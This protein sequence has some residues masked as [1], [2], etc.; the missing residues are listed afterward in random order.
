MSFRQDP[1]RLPA[2]PPSA[3]S[4]TDVDASPAAA[5]DVEKA[6]SDAEHTEDAVFGKL[7]GG[8]ALDYRAVGAKGAFVLLVKVNLG[9]GVL[10]LPH[11]FGVLG[12]VPGILAILV[13]QT[14]FCYC[15]LMIGRFK[16]AHPQ[17]YTV[18][19]AAA[20][21]GGRWAKEFW[22][23]ALNLQ[24]IFFVAAACVGV[25][26]ALNAVSAHGACTAI[27]IAVAGVLAFMFGA[28]PTLGAI[29]WI[30]WA[31]LASIL[32]AVFTV[33]VA[34]GVQSRPSLA[35]ATGP[36][37][38]NVKMF[39]DA[40]FAQAMAAINQ[41]LFAYGSTPMFFGIASEMRE[42][43]K[44]THSMVASIGFLTTVYLV[45]GVVVYHYCG[46]Y[47]ASPS[48]GSAGPLLKKICY[49][50]AIPGL[51]ASMTLF[52]HMASKNIFVR[53]LAGSRHLAANTPTHWA[54]WL[55]ITAGCALIGYVI[56][57]AIPIF[58]SLISIIGALVVPSLSVI[59]YTFMWW[60]DNYRF[61][62]AEER[63]LR[64]R[65]TFYLNVLILVIAFF[66]TAA[67]TYGAV[68]DLI[69][70]TNNSKPWTCHDNSGTVKD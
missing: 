34:V 26:T 52:T 25:S 32:A 21:F 59:P 54:A 7:Q 3:G 9:L 40:T 60:H 55:G 70:T 13:I 51:L 31:G 8:K 43:R 11:A 61:V 62:P 57:S 39:G 18:S 64:K 66:L 5:R 1:K 6:S 29:T 2:S 42:P 35:P 53:A 41:I 36:F 27:F 16:I 44:F 50:I 24:M 67:G 69:N 48:L 63:T 19:D 33:T 14:I 58:D 23:F 22:F 12:L 65:L 38:K 17:V 45:V 49:G 15:A 20:V 30:G 28:I 46:Q 10:G 47:V 56:A 4:D 37:D 68:D